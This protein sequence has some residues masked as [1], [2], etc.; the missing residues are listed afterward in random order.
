MDHANLGA[1]VHVQSELMYHPTQWESP[2]R[3]HAQL[4]RHALL[5]YN[6]S[7]DCKAVLHNEKRTKVIARSVGFRGVPWLSRARCNGVFYSVL[8]KITL[9]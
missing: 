7:Q 9:N 1:F 8:T 4:F 5:V 3:T 6:G 2:C